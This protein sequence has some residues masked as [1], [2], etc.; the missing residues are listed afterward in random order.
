[1]S[2]DEILERE[3]R[4][5]TPV[6]V[7]SIAAVAF[8]V[9][10]IVVS[11]QADLSAKRDSVN[12][13]EFDAHSGDLLL[14]AVFAAIGLVLLIAPLLHLFKA[15]EARS[16]SVRRGFVGLPVAGPLF[17]AANGVIK[18]FALDQVSGDFLSGPRQTEAVADRLLRESALQDLSEGL[19]LAGVLGLAVAIVYTSL[20]AM[21]TGLLTRFLGSLGMAL[22]VACVLL[23]LL[24]AAYLFLGFMGLIAAGWW[25]GPRPPAWDA[26]VAIPWPSPGEQAVARDI[27][28]DPI[29]EDKEGSD[30]PSPGAPMRKRKRRR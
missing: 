11:R 24:P 7:A 15:A 28:P 2:V 20:H 9:I 30:E 13:R 25:P 14:A 22:G 5:A 1:M 4:W 17:L 19:L 26:G 27:P 3:R 18:W 12:L 16:E 8:Q 23:G 10:S 21:R 6:A 29:E